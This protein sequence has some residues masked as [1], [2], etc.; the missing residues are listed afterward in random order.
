AD[1]SLGM[2]LAS[3]FDWNDGEQEMKRALELNPKLALAYDQLA[4]VQTV[5]G[6][7]E[8]AIRNEQKAIELDPLSLLFN[9]DLGWV[10]TTARRY[11]EA[12]AQYRK[13]LE[14]DPNFAVAHSGLG[15]SGLGWCFVYKG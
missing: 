5:S 13:T 4:W 10:L 8:E 12:I 15:G 3:A 2:A 7:F 9:S 14:L 11:D 6:R 1:L